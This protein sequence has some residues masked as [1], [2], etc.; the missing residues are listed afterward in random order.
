MNFVKIMV[1]SYFSWVF[2]CNA[3]VCME[4]GHTEIGK[5]VLSIV[6]VLKSKV[7]RTGTYRVA[8]GDT[9]VAS[10]GQSVLSRRDNVSSRREWTVLVGSRR[11]ALRSR[12]DALLKKKIVVFG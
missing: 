2:L 3:N 1:M 4:V 6:Q 11:D 9:R 12:R 8:I 10:L 7:C 5:M